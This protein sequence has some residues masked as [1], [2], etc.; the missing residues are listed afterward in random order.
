MRIWF[1]RHYALVARVCRLLRE[2][3]QPLPL[4]L[5]VSHRH[6]DFIGFAFADLAFVEPSDL[7]SADYV[8]WALAVA[9]QKSID[10]LIPGHHASAL[11][12][13]SDQ[14][15]AIGVRLLAAASADILPN[16]NRKDWVYAN[17]P[18]GVRVPQH[19]VVNDAGSLEAALEQI[20]DSGDACIKPTVSV[21][22]LGY[23]RMLSPRQAAL[24]PAA[25]HEL[26]LAEWRSRYSKPPS[27]GKPQLVMAYLPGPEY[28]VD[29]A[30]QGGEV[31]AAV[32]R[33]KPLFGIGQELVE[34]AEIKTA[35]AQLVAAFQLSGLI[36]IQ[37]REDAAGLPY[38][39]EINPRASGGIGMSC[40]SGLNLPDIALRACLFGERRALPPPRLGLRVAELPQ[41]I[42]LPDRLPELLPAMLPEALQGLQH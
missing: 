36:N 8:A 16:L 2:A 17:A 13:A 6:H 7:S 5:A 1:N 14:F 38:L 33:K 24:R 4:T 27:E 3:E 23:H 34:L 10:V 41:A 26:T 9:K 21:Y 37:F 28:S 15:A 18:A 12:S 20:E 19:V 11:A 29:L 31:L 35:A 42:A 30:C 40:L 32:Q 39:L 25:S 22:G